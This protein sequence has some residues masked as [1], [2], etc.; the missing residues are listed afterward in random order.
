MKKLLY[1]FLAFGLFFSC[2]ENKDNDLDKENLNGEVKSVYTAS[3]EAIKKFGEVTKGNKKWKYDFLSDNETI[4]D[5]KGNQIE[6]ANYDEDGKLTSK[7][8]SKFDDKGNEI[9]EADYYNGKL[10]SKYKYKYHFDDNK[11]WIKKIIVK[12]DKATFIIEREI[13]YYN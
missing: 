11:N 12:D 10:Y 6:E 13:E 2:S 7:W 9:E 4:Y 8:K 3:F 1:I 5:D